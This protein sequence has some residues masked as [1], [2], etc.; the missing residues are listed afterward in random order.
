MKYFLFILWLSV[1]VMYSQVTSSDKSELV[2]K[3]L[4][5]Y[6]QSNKHFELVLNDKQILY[7]SEIVEI[8]SISLTVNVLID[9]RLGQSRNFESLVK[10]EIEN[11]FPKLLRKINLVDVYAV[12]ELRR[13]LAFNQLPYPPTTLIIVVPLTLLLVKLISTMLVG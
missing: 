2:Y 10:Q 9:R 4:M 7:V 12:K 11:N 6:K 8:D 1:S 5:G 13:S 3:N